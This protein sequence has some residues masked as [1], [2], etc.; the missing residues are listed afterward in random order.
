MDV[1]RAGKIFA[2]AIP[3]L[4]QGMVG[5]V[6][7]PVIFGST[8]NLSPISILLAL[9]FFGA[10]WGLSGAIVSVPLLVRTQHTHAHG[11]ARTESQRP[12]ARH[13]DY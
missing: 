13:A 1:P 3:T 4:A 6:I 10:M 9:V 12:H 5:N 2:V 8:L 7:E 11:A